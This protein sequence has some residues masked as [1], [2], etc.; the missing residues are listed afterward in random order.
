ME[1]T[2]A[3]VSTNEVNKS[4]LKKITMQSTYTGAI[5]RLLLKW[6]GCDCMGRFNA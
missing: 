6:N 4:P 2:V 3:A 5:E 1:V